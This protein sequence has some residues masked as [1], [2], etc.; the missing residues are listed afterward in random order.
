VFI[1]SA[2]PAERAFLVKQ[3]WELKR[4]P[5]KST[6]CIAFSLVDKY[7]CRTS[8][9]HLHQLGADN[10]CLAE[11]AALFS[12]VKHRIVDDEN[13]DADVPE[14]SEL[15]SD[16]AATEQVSVSTI[17]DFG[18]RRYYKRTQERVIRYVHYKLHD[19]PEAYYREQLLLYYPWSANTSKPLCLSVNEDSYLLDGHESF[20][21]RYLSVQADIAKN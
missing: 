18:H 15:Q 20:E 3:D 4:L 21:S 19:N 8:N 6:N 5:P 14:G 9:P 1:P 13:D 11:F 7:A 17:N 12:P 16:L 2:A 10:V